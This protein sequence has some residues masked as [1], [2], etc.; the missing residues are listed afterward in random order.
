MHRI[1]R[2]CF[3]I[4]CLLSSQTVAAQEIL[5]TDSTSSYSVSDALEYYIDSTGLLTLQSIRDLP[6]TAW[7]KSSSEF[8]NL[9][10]NSNSDW[11]RVRLKNR[12]LSETRLLVWEFPWGDRAEL[13]ILEDGKQIAHQI[14]GIDTPIVSREYR[15]RIPVAKLHT[16]SGTDQ[17]LY[18][19]MQSTGTKAAV[20]YLESEVDFLKRDHRHGFLFHLFLSALA[21]MIA[22]NF[23]LAY[24]S[25]SHGPLLYVLVLFFFALS[26]AVFRSYL[27]DA[28][29]PHAPEWRHRGSYIFGPLQGIA[30]IF[31]WCWLL[32]L[33]VHSPRLER[34]LHLAA[35]GFLLLILYALSPDPDYLL[36]NRVGKSIFYCIA[37]IFVTTAV[38]ALRK[39]F[40]PAFYSV[41]G[42][43]FLQGSIAV[44]FLSTSGL[45]SMN[46]WTLNS[47]YLGLVPEFIFFMLS[48][49]SRM[50]FL[51]SLH[52]N[53]IGATEEQQV[54]AY[55]EH[56]ESKDHKYKKSKIRTV[57]IKAILIQL[58][59]LMSSEKL[60]CDEDLSL[61][62]LAGLLSITPYQLSEIVNATYGKNFFR[63]I[64]E[65]RIAEARTLLRND[66]RRPIASIAQSVGFNSLSS[67]NTEFKRIAGTT[68]SQF[69]R[70]SAE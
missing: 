16:P 34:A 1:V 13:F 2:S 70:A 59:R 67:F 27:T 28:F 18:I 22:L 66:V 48:V 58:N 53:G 32:L 15:H 3:I 37:I 42:F 44:Y 60:F 14:I 12:S 46:E 25:R 5:L 41:P 54:A 23:I 61:Q 4:V 64:N 57:N 17:E 62:R 19:R 45:I 47:L 50:R 26:V 49:F 40:H 8:L 68:P 29:F 21:F 55:R 6:A 36:L 24:T 20:F 10:T 65:Y 30:Q 38:L 7:K 51:T 43:I 33:R 9:G 52:P 31:F 11:L 56:I 63:F 35:F 69:R 39:G